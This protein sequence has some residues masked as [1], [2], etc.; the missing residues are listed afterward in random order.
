VSAAASLMPPPLPP[1]VPTGRTRAPAS[2][3]SSC[4]YPM[5][6]Q[7]SHAPIAIAT[8]QAYGDRRRSLAAT[9]V[10]R[11]SGLVG[12]NDRTCKSEASAP[13]SWANHDSEAPSKRCR[14][15]STVPTTEHLVRFTDLPDQSKRLFMGVSDGTPWSHR[16]HRG[17]RRRRSR[18]VRFRRVEPGSGGFVGWR[19]RGNGRIGWHGRRCWRRRARR[20][21]VRCG[22]AWCRRR[23][24]AFRRRADRYGWRLAG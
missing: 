24:D 21:R 4:S 23:D 18:G 5:R 6:P 7:P 8:A 19:W 11:T 14:S 1:P 9:R 2:S 3:S 16:L 12:K 22:D 13:L 20:D 15:V 17:V 10:L